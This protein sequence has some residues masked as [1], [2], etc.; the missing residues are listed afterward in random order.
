M[1]HFLSA[2]YLTSD[3]NFARDHRGLDKR[4]P[5]DSGTAPPHALPELHKPGE[6]CI[7]LQVGFGVLCLLW[8]RQAGMQQPLRGM[9][10]TGK[11]TPATLESEH[12]A[13]HA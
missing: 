13:D 3:V 5:E 7:A 11:M 8:Q 10:L 12:D 6:G 9:G 2:A 4:H 1:R